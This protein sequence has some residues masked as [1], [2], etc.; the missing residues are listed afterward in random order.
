[1]DLA[2][3]IGA[4][5]V[6][7]VVG[8]AA[9]AD[10]AQDAQEALSRSGAHGKLIF[11]AVPSEA[12]VEATIRGLKPYASKVRV[13][14][15]EAGP[16]YGFKPQQRTALLGRFVDAGFRGCSGW[17]LMSEIVGSDSTAQRAH[18]KLL[19]QGR[20]VGAH[21]LLIVDAKPFTD[22]GQRFMEEGVVVKGAGTGADRLFADL[23]TSQAREVRNDQSFAV[24]AA[25]AS[26]QILGGVDW[27]CMNGD[28]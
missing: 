14:V 23:G 16:V 19:D 12:E 26:E 17:G 4:A 25:L 3:L 8:T 20:S 13:G 27:D 28:R 7:M 6:G 9:T 24:G 10:V 18:A 1:M 22:A 15:G 11:L 21:S 2:R 5:L